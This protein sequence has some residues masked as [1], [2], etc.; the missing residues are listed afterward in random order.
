MET[1]DSGRVADAEVTHLSLLPRPCG[2]QSMAVPMAALWELATGGLRSLRRPHCSLGGRCL[3]LLLEE[4][5]ARALGDGVGVGQRREGGAP[6][7]DGAHDALVHL[8]QVVQVLEY[9]R[10]S[11][12]V[13]LP[14]EG[15]RRSGEKCV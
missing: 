15:L 7:H 6:Q 3:C 4:Q 11:R 14:Q 13:E 12:K 10:R 2:G 5:A 1:W 8:E 9:I